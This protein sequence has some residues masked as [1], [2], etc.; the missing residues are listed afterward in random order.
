MGFSI[1]AALTQ[2]SGTCEFSEQAFKNICQR[3]NIVKAIN[4]QNFL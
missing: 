3:L 4:Q 1:L 2:I